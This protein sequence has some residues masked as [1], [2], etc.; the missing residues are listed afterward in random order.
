MSDRNGSD[1]PPELD[2]LSQLRSAPVPP[3]WLEERVASDLRRSGLLVPNRDRHGWRR[4]L[5]ANKLD[6]DGRIVA[7]DAVRADAGPLS[8]FFLI[9]ADTYDQAVDTALNC[10]HLRHGGTIEVRQIDR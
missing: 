1:T 2:E 6:E 9:R 7:N 5:L 4:Y 3:S 10:P 8:G